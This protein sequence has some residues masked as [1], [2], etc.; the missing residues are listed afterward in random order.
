[1]SRHE[2]DIVQ[3][4]PGGRLRVRVD[5]PGGPDRV[6]AAAP[7]P[8]LVELGRA[9]PAPST[10]ARFKQTDSD[11]DSFGDGYG[12]ATAEGR[13]EHHQRDLTDGLTVARWSTSAF[14]AVTQLWARDGGS[15]GSAVK[16]VEDG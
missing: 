7:G 13:D 9:A 14:A 10:P 16:G 3:R 12:S 15:V 5:D 8:P 6:R 11:V 2:H 1:M 4:P